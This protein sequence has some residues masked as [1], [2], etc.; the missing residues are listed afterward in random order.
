VRGCGAW[1]VINA[2]FRGREN[3]QSLRGRTPQFRGDS[4]ILARWLLIVFQAQGGPFG[5]RFTLSAM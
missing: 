1:G 3:N 4:I 5:I 2:D